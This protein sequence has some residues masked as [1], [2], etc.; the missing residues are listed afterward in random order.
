MKLKKISEVR[1]V[2]IDSMRLQFQHGHKLTEV[3]EPQSIPA[4]ACVYRIEH[5]GRRTAS[6][7]I[8]CTPE[9]AA[10]L[11]ERMKVEIE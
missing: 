1:R 11:A 5:D 10:Y 6:S 2:H 8:I 7:D 4:G 9:T 3:I